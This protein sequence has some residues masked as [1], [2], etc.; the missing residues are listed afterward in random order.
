VK[1]VEFTTELNGSSLLAI[2]EEVARQL[3]A[4]GR[5]RVIV[6]TADDADD[7]DWRLAAYGQF[8]RDDPPEDAAYDALR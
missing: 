6:L 4:A 2:P 3:P 1:A 8:L 7:A 5:A